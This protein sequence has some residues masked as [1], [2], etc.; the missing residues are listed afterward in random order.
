MVSLFCYKASWNPVQ[1]WY[2][3]G[4]LMDYLLP[5]PTGYYF[6]LAVP[7]DLQ[8]I[9]RKRELKKS[10]KTCN[11]TIA[12]RQALFYASY[13]HHTFEQLRGKSLT[14]PLFTHLKNVQM[15]RT[16]D[17]E[18]R[19]DGYLARPRHHTLQCRSLTASSVARRSP[20][21]CR[22]AFLPT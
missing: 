18:F 16:L 14:E 9:F 3:M 6:R 17:G 21:S 4:V 19:L 11:H 2:K 1:N 15:S 22:S 10:L 20:S 7:K 13:W 12:T 5:T 8:P